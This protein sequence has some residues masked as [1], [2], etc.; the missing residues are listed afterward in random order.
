MKYYTQ[1][2]LKSKLFY[3]MFF[4][5]NVSLE[6]YIIKENFLKKLG[7]HENAIEQINNE[8]IIHCKDYFNENILFYDELSKY[9]FDSNG[10]LMLLD[11][12]LFFKLRFYGI[13][14]LNILNENRNFFEEERKRFKDS[15]YPEAII[16]LSESKFHDADVVFDYKD[17][18]LFIRFNPEENEQIF[19]FHGVENWQEKEFM[20]KEPVL[21]VDEL[22]EETPGNFI[23]N[24]L[25]YHADIGGQN[26][27]ELS[28]K[29]NNLIQVK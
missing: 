18:K 17:N 21:L 24:T 23:Y 29:F 7:T 9:L 6:H 19:E 22:L 4:L 5:P 14:F 27:S 28:I 13:K 11:E 20:K 26:N 25:W 3:E 8:F 16:T 12:Y 1:K 15:S 10:E 2:F